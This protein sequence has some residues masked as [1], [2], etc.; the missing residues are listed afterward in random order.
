MVAPIVAIQG[1][2]AAVATGLLYL[3]AQRDYA[4]LAQQTPIPIDVYVGEPHPAFLDQLQCVVIHWYTRLTRT[5]HTDPFRLMAEADDRIPGLQRTRA[6]REN[7]TATTTGQSQA[8][9]VLGTI[10][11]Y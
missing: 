6:A 5:I 11:K 4:R 7:E 3:W 10:R 8:P 1:A 2:V 9:L